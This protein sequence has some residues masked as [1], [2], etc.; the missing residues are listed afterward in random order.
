MFNELKGILL[1]GKGCKSHEKILVSYLSLMGREL[2]L[3]NF[4]HRIFSLQ[5]TL[6]TT[7]VLINNYEKDPNSLPK[8]RKLL[9]DASKDVILLSEILSYCKESI[10]SLKLPEKPKDEAGQKL[11]KIFDMEKR[12]KDFI[13]RVTDLG[14]NIKGAKHEIDGLREMTEVVSETQMFRVQEAL[15]ANT[16][17]LE[18]VFRANE[19]AS[20]S[21]EVLQFILAGTLAFQI[22]DRITGGWS[23]ENTGK[24]QNFN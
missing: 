20:S 8:I 6:T 9:S 16:K 18:E 4:F 19:R 5:D 2:F 12:Y 17:N 1:A 14:K 24:L 11:F 22:L 21:L 15:Q 3:D 7:R 13:Q 23:L 10:D